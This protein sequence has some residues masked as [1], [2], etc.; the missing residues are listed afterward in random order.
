MWPIEPR[1][2]RLSGFQLAKLEDYE[3]AWCLAANSLAESNRNMAEGA[4]RRL[5][6]ALGEPVPPVYWVRSPDEL[7][8]ARL[9]RLADRQAH[10]RPR[11][12]RPHPWS[13][14]WPL[15][16]LWEPLLRD[17][18]VAGGEMTFDAWAPIEGM[19]MAVAERLTGTAMRRFELEIDRA[20]DGMLEAHGWPAQFFGTLAAL[21]F[22]YSRVMPDLASPRSLA[23]VELFRYCGS[24]FPEHDVCWLIERPLMTVVGEG[25]R[26][27]CDTGP[28]IVYRDGW[29]AC[30]LNGRWVPE[31][32]VL[33]P[34]E[35]T[36][37]D[38]QLQPDGEARE[39]MIR[40]YGIERYLKD[41]GAKIVSDDAFGTLYWLETQ[42]NVNGRQILRVTDKTVG[43]DGVQKEYYLQVPMKIKTAREGVAWTFGITEE[44]Y[45]PSLE[46]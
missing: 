34:A 23:L 26:L 6:E 10:P 20:T 30:Y 43:R 38:I 37:E 44:E 22:V 1:I 29:G 7:R 17:Y 25:E 40:R 27:H 18:L 19:A 12:R 11:P 24:C 28:A 3:E 13:V 35:I 21:D 46:T 41:L 9:L 45:S 32:V 4:A 42:A 2:R 16:M 15:R 39:E 31:H 33:R 14:D 5:Y 36:L 8:L